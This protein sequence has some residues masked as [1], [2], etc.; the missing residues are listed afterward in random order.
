M[1][2]LI[3]PLDSPA[4]AEFVRAL[5]PINRLA[6]VSPGFVWRLQDDDG[7]P[8]SFMTIPEIDDA[9]M[10]VNYSIWEDLDSLT[11]FVYRSGHGAY[12]RRRREWFEP[13]AEAQTVCWWVPAGE[14]PPTS[15]GLARLMHLRAHGPSERGWPPNK[16]FPKPAE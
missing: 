2:R 11:H 9:Q 5:E 1:A 15:E 16:P 7:G 8:S 6:E 10:L 14:V 4:S 13:S 3:E 12:F